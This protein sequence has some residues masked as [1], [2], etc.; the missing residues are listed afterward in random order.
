MF[1]TLEHLLQ[2]HGADA[3]VVVWAHNSHIGDARHTEMGEARDEL[4]LGQL[5]RERFGEQ[6]ALI[7][8]GTHGGTVAAA[9]NWDEPMQVMPIK[10]SLPES[11]ERLFHDAGVPRGLLDL[12]EEAHPALRDRLLQQRL[13]RFIGVIY[14]PDTERWSHYT[15]ATL[16][17]QFDGYLW[18]DE[19]RAVE[20]TAPETRQGVPDTYP[21][22][23]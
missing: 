9:Q 7:G 15:R 13:E 22:G 1:E 12:R 16:P 3:K 5:C 14:R 2:A 23:L 11:Y 4:N 21:F 19:T 20:E 6:V 10:P 17:R 8:L 18:F